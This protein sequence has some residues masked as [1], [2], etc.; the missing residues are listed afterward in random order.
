MDMKEPSGIDATE[1]KGKS[2]RTR[3]KPGAKPPTS[4]AGKRSLNLRIDED[5]YQRLN[6]HAL[7]RKKTVSEL[8]MEYAQGHLKEFVVHRRPG[9]TEG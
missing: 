6:V 3:R 2:A 7:M 8:V 1:D 5:S 9:S 4:E